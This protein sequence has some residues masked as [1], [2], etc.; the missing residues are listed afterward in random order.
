MNLPN[1]L[2]IFRIMLVPLII[3]VWLFPYA[4]FNIDL[5]SVDVG[6][7]TLSFK[8]IVAFTIF[9]IASITDFFDGYLARKYN[10][11]TTFGKFADPIADKMLVNTMLLLLSNSNYLIILPVIIM[12][13]RDIIVDGMRMLASNNGVVVSAGY[14]GKLKTVSQMI[15]I[16]FC[17]LGNLPFEL[18][19]IP[20]VD[21][22]LWFTT[23]ISV[24]SGVSYYIQLK[25]Y[26]F[27]SK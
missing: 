27:E 26:I 6:V 9:T 24:I 5:P 25:D 22:M 17:L 21:F 11:M 19:N 3:L 13:T 14:L 23:F 18:K 1:K 7:V 16:V 12:I 8:A 10:L 4:E 15:L 2:T 20:F